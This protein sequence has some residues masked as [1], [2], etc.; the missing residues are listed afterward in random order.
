MKKFNSFINDKNNNI[1]NE[2]SSR[3][4][5][6]LYLGKEIKETVIEFFLNYVGEEIFHEAVAAAAPSTVTANPAQTQTQAGTQQKKVI[7]LTEPTKDIIEII[8]NTI[9]DL[10]RIYS[11]NIG[12]SQKDTNVANTYISFANTVGKKLM[13]SIPAL[14]RNSAVEVQKTMNQEKQEKTRIANEAGIQ[15][16]AALF[17]TP[18]G[19]QAFNSLN[20]QTKSQLAATLASLSPDEKN[21]LNNIKGGYKNKLAFLQMNP[22]QRQA[23]MQTPARVR[24]AKAAAPS[25]PAAATPSAPAPAT[26]PS[27]PAAATSSAPAPAAAPAATSNIYGGRIQ[28]DP[29]MYNPTRMENHYRAKGFENFIERRKAEK[30]I[31]D[32]AIEFIKTNDIEKLLN[33]F[34]SYLNG[35]RCRALNEAVMNPDPTQPQPTQQN[36]SGF[37]F[38][39]TSL[40]GPEVFQKTRFQDMGTQIVNNIKKFTNEKLQ[41]MEPDNKKIFSQIF[42]KLVSSVISNLRN[43]M[44]TTVTDFEEKAVKQG[45]EG[46]EGILSSNRTKNFNMIM[47]RLGYADPERYLSEMGHFLSKGD[48]HIVNDKVQ[49][50]RKKLEEPEYQHNKKLIEEFLKQLVSTT[51]PKELDKAMRNQS[52]QQIKD[53]FAFSGGTLWLLGAIGGELF[54]R[55]GPTIKKGIIDGVEKIQPYLEKFGDL[56]SMPAGTG[57]LAAHPMEFKPEG[58]RKAAPENASEKPKGMFSRFGDWWKKRTD[59]SGAGSAVKRGAGKLVRG[60]RQKAKSAKDWIK[61]H[62]TR[63]MYD[64]EGYTWG[65]QAQTDFS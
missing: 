16:V 5:K 9:G 20:D 43:H 48:F 39:R 54:K 11:H 59:L 15:A 45:A 42:N 24:K 6:E 40:F 14:L 19:Q 12:K 25:T 21:Y 52:I 31:E 47:K 13:D 4:I 30:F 62:F 28:F 56:W 32:S 17:N 3:I 34:V 53:F 46:Y 27:A 57:G 58:E 60:A 29:R 41:E 10:K 33:E 55:Y 8:R 26:A 49:R 35:D 50:L 63:P 7:T 1:V 22:Q 18:Q 65:G 51:D 64:P 2:Y 38:G 44:Q 37:Q 23:K 61:G 36:K